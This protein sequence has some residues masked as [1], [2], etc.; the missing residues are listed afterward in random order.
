MLSLSCCSFAVVDS[1]LAQENQAKRL[2]MKMGTAFI[3]FL[4]GLVGI[5]TMI[6]SHRLQHIRTV[7]AVQLI[8][9]GM[10]FGVAIVIAAW[11]RKAGS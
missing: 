8:A 3:A 1:S 9:S 10:C 11:S 6:G 5:S 4:V 7:D 2:V